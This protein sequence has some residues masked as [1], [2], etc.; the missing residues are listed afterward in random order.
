[1]TE[2]LSGRHGKANQELIQL[3][4]EA[5]GATKAYIRIKLDATSRTKCVAVD[6]A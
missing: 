3:L 5:L 6:M 1:M 2:V 4:A